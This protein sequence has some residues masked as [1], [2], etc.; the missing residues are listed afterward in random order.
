M[1][2]VPSRVLARWLKRQMPKTLFGRSLLIIVLPVALMQIAV[3]WIF[4]DAHWQTVTSR[5]SE[6]LAGDIAWAVESYGDDPGPEAFARLSERAEESMGL[7]I[8]L[9]PGRKLPAR[10]RDPPA[11]LEPFF[12]PIDRSLERALEA[13]LDA[14]Y[15]FDTTRYPAYV[16]IRVAV[17]GGVMR[18][19]APRERAF[20]TQGHIFVLWM[21]LATVLLTGIAIVF[22]RNQV[23]AIERLANAAEAFGRGTDVPYFKPHGA[24]EV[25]RAA[26][27]F[28]DMRSR[29]QRHIDQRT[30]LLA[31]VS[32]DLRTPLTRLKLELA[33]AEP[34]A[35]TAAMK[36]DL[37]EME[38]MIDEYLAFARGEGG[39]AVETVRLRDLLD[40]VSEGARRAGAAVGLEA[41]AELTANVRPNALKRALSNLVMNAAV[42]GEHVQ[43]AARPRPSGGVE[44]VVDDDGPGIPADQY[45]EAFKAFGRLDESRN[46]NTKGVGLGLA[47]ARDVARGHGGDILLDRSPLG[48]LR[49]VLRLPG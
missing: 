2:L 20:A 44:I 34:S 29:I 10:R 17:P 27:A 41:D 46:Q 47:I 31:A 32:H 22:I 8:A 26:H 15:W 24:R 38:H 18:V 43:V 7:S 40:E 11:A 16:D 30:T 33:L 21:T 37:A 5:L 19:L 3:T 1:R 25:R 36:T 48:G 39:E 4:F 42:H 45:E 12:A 14:P 23:R 9:Q 13:R 35:R 49:A 28:I 6:G